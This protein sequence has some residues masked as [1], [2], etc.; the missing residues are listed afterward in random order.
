MDKSPM[1]RLLAWIKQLQ[2]K[3][4]NS[5]IRVDT[6]A[7]VK[8]TGGPHFIQVDNDEENSGET[9]LYWW[10]GSQLQWVPTQTI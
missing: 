2:C 9:T 4:D 6:F 7:D 3:V 10:T 8:L 5:Y 1:G